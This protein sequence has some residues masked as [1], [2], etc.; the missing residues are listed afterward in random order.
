[1]RRE[2]FLNHWDLGDF[3]DLLYILLHSWAWFDDQRTSFNLFFILLRHLFA[4]LDECRTSL[5]ERVTKE[6]HEFH[7][8]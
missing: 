2:L 6:D 8:C 1:M 5:S 3:L 7:D 4:A